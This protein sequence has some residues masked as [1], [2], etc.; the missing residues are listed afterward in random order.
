MKLTKNRIDIMR[1]LTQGHFDC[2]DAPFAVSSIHYMIYG[3]D[4][5]LAKEKMRCN[6]IRRTL[7]DFLDNG[8]VVSRKKDYDGISALLGKRISNLRND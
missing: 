6:Q 5:D 4:S 2:G 1:H 7:N 3:F 8:I